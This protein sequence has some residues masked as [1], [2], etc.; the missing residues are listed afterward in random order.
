M[1]VS[2]FL[3]VYVFYL[4]P[5]KDVNS[6]LPPSVVCFWVAIFPQQ[7]VILTDLN[8]CNIKKIWKQESDLLELK[9]P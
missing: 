1:P 5:M 2:E 9:R 8:K 3:A 6:F 7:Q 4:L